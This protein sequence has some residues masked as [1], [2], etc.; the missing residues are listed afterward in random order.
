MAPGHARCRPRNPG[1]ALRG[2]SRAAVR[3]DARPWAHAA[4]GAVAETRQHRAGGQP[5]GGA[6]RPHPARAGR[7]GAVDG[8]GGSARQGRGQ[9]A[10][11]ARARGGDA[12]H[13]Q[14]HGR[15]RRRHP[16]RRGR[17]MGL[18]GSPAH[19]PKRD[20]RGDTAPRAL[21]HPQ[22]GRATA[23][24]G[25]TRPRRRRRVGRPRPARPAGEA[26]R[27]P[28]GAAH[29]RGHRLARGARARDALHAR[30]RAPRRT[31][32]DPQHAHQRHLP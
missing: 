26:H 1:H 11:M 29:P 20:A 3:V 22:R 15:P 30:R 25:L 4:R 6:A 9:T 32:E 27:T 24:H 14:A 16:R 5:A 19:G 28:R 17:A 18:E 23:G 31:Q 10:A 13:P 21:R 8:G 12:R 7:H 2:L